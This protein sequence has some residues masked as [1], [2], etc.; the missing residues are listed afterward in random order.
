MLQGTLLVVTG[1]SH[2]HAFSFYS[3]FPLYFLHVT[4]ARPCPFT[5]QP[6]TI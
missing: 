2:G 6:C 5:A 4:S 1:T 3:P